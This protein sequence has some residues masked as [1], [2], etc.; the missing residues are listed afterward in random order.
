MKSRGTRRHS[1]SIEQIKFYDSEGNE[2]KPRVA[3][4]EHGIVVFD[5]PVAMVDF[6]VPVEWQEAA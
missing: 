3:N 1:M 2:L 6:P 4:A 5:Q